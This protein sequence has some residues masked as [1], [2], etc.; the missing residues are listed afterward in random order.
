MPIIMKKVLA[1]LF[2]VALGL[3]L[4]AQV[5]DYVPTEGLVAWYPFNGNANDESGNGY[6]GAT[7]NVEPTLDR[8]GNENAAYEFDGESSYV[9]VESDFDSNERSA[10]LWVRASSI[11]NSLVY[12]TDHNNLEFGL[13]QFGCGSFGSAFGI[14]VGHP[15]GENTYFNQTATIDT[16]YMLAFTRNA[17]STKY[18][19]N[20]NLEHTVENANF[21]SV[22]GAAGT[23]IGVRRG[24]GDRFFNGCIDDIGIWTTALSDEQITALYNAQLPIPGCT[25]WNADNYNPNA[26]IED[27][28]CLYSGCIDMEA[29]NYDPQAN[30]GDQE[31][32]CEYYGCTNETADNYD[33]NANVDDGSCVG[34]GCMTDVCEYY[35]CTDAE[36][37]NYDPQANVEDGSCLYSGCIDMEADNYDPQANTGDQ[38]ALCEYNGCTNEAADH[39]DPNANLDDG[40]CIVAGCMYA[41]ASNYNA[42]A[43]YDNFS[44]EFL[45]PSVYCG[46]GTYWDDFA[47][48]CL[49]IVT[50][51]DDLD[52]DGVIGVNDLMQLLSSFG[53]DCAPTEEPETTEFTCGDPVTYHGYDYATVQI[54][55]QCWFAENLRNEHYANGDAIP[56]ELSNTEWVST[57]SGAQAV[58][59]ND[60]SNLADYGRLYNLYAAVYDERG[61]CP[62]GWH[63][64]TDGEYM[65]LEMA[66]GMSESE[67]DDTGWRGTDQGNQMKSSPSDGH[68]WDGTNTSGFSALAG[69]WRSSNGNFVYEGDFGYFWSSSPVGVSAWGRKLG[70]GFTGV[71]RNYN[72]GLRYGKSVRCVRD[73]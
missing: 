28:S 23:W 33:P 58:Y 24:A 46:E 21:S 35:G 7:Q 1:A 31:A 60:A 3:N 8:F 66:L 13:T 62:S 69:G 27:G 63:V 16:W 68:S 9:F 41:A 42:V 59:N 37:D 20:G 32:L 65:T 25:D 19:F 30:T 55:E 56:G 17:D 54:G 34:E 72:G 18:Y 51:Q 70:S 22:S 10:C 6:D 71:Y 53:T 4:S 57:N 12:D 38:E 43:T 64:P 45:I 67:A 47:Q 44:C 73:E 50:C 14:G 48:A 5:P 61:L 52:G 11:E 15:G 39:Y 49:T 40:S 36:G 29:D 2:A 26:N